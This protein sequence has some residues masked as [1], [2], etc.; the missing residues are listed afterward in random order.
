MLAFVNAVIYSCHS[1]TRDMHLVTQ[2]LV[3]LRQTLFH[4]RVLLSWKPDLR[5][6]R[7]Q[8]RQD[9]TTKSQHGGS[10]RHWEVARLGPQLVGAGRVQYHAT[11]GLRTD[12]VKHI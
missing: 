10:H 3:L 8:R 4:R 5:R 9:A 1:E 7:S 11:D 6:V 2:Q 12:T